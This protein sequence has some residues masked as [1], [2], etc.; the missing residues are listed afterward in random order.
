MKAAIA[1]AV[2]PAALLD[3]H[4]EVGDAG[5]EERDR[6]HRHQDLHGVEPAAPRHLV[7]AG[8]AEVPAQEA[9]DE[10]PAGLRRK[11]EEPR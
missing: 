6:H 1:V 9:D 11:P 8:G 3:H 2:L 10:G 5:D 7:E 4:E